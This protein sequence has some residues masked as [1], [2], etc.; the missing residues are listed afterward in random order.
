MTPG[1]QSKEKTF[2][3]ASGGGI[4]GVEPRSTYDTA[5]EQERTQKAQKD[6]E[7]I[8]NAQI[9][10]SEHTYQ[11]KTGQADLA[12]FENDA[13]A[14][15]DLGEITDEQLQNFKQKTEDEAIA[16]YNNGNITKDEFKATIDDLKDNLG[17]LGVIAKKGYD[18][19]LKKQKAT[20]T[21]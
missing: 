11:M 12:S 21:G 3:T 1:E 2:N 6:Q 16:Q 13:L 8:R 10:K 18:T 17:T 4:G 15:Y 9:A 7:K 20:P 14:R 19:Y 5:L